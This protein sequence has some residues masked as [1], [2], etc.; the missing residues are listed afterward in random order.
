MNKIFI[1]D[2]DS[3]REL[4]EVQF[5]TEVDKISYD[6]SRGYVLI[7]CDYPIE[8][9]IKMYAAIKQGIV[10]MLFTKSTTD[11]TKAIME[12]RISAHFNPKPGGFQITAS[13]GVA[14]QAKLLYATK[15]QRDKHSEILIQQLE[16]TNNDVVFNTRNVGSGPWI[17]AVR[18][19]KKVGATMLMTNKRN[20]EKIERMINENP[21]TVICS[22]PLLM[23]RLI[24]LTDVHNEK[25]NIRCWHVSGSATEPDDAYAMEAIM[26]GCKFIQTLGRAEGVLPY[27]CDLDDLSYHRIETIGKE[28][29]PGST[30]IV[31][32]EMQISKEWM[33]P[34]LDGEYDFTDDGWYHTG[35]L[36]KQDEDGYIKVLG[37]IKPILS[38]GP[39]DI[40][41]LEILEIV[42]AMD[43]VDNTHCFKDEDVP[44]VCVWCNSGTISEEDI[45]QAVMESLNLEIRVQIMTGDYIDFNPLSM[46]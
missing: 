19:C 45:E 41:P 38:F 1:K 20:P 6:A 12:Q 2:A 3:G 31:A 30:R 43:Y 34:M 29:V 7:D 26:N 4:S 33:I 37:C 22:T 16:L 27:G 36:V 17:N 40:N 25:G 32:G 21:I 5:D 24:T 39:R 13:G 8:M 15:E 10:F 14:S 9:A 35:D 42:D 44:V 28:I 46:L 23:K 18:Q 11:F